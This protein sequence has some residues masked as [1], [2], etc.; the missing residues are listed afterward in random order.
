M[1]KTWLLT[2]GS[3]N[4]FQH[5][6]RGKYINAAITVGFSIA[7]ILYFSFTMDHIRNRA[8]S[9]RL[10]HSK[11][12]TSLPTI[13]APKNVVA[14]SQTTPTNHTW[15][16]KPVKG[17]IAHPETTWML[18]K[19]QDDPADLD[20]VEAPVEYRAKPVA[21]RLIVMTMNRHR[22]LKR[23]LRSAAEA[24]YGGHRIDLDIWVDRRSV[25]EEL[26]ANVLNVTETQ[27]WPHGTKTIYRRR[28]PGGLYQQWIW[29]WNPSEDSDEFA[30]ILEDDLELSP[31]WYEWLTEARR[32]YGND[33]DT[34]GFTLQRL[35]LQL[36]GKKKILT[37]PENTPVFK[38]H[39][40][41]SWGF[42]PKR[43]V[44]LEFRKWFEETVRAGKKPYVHDLLSS[45]WY[46][47]QDRRHLGYAPSMWTQWFIKFV[48][49]RSYFTV[50]PHLLDG[51][52][53][54]ANWKEPGLHYSRKNR[55]RKDFP[56]F[57]GNSTQ[58]S[59]P[60]TLLKFDWDGTILNPEA[61]DE[62]V[63]M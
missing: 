48:D 49:E 16:P 34:A 60:K 20:T 43:E 29:T 33:K 53:V 40:L 51:T 23:L 41:G 44:W 39:L 7:L 46:R 56:L 18:V 24:R 1:N 3:K 25:E 11:L 32:R 27:D 26:D 38:N 5:Q 31:A 35:I 17:K 14:Q 62:N 42:A 4:V 55:P 45:R 15:P 63:Q 52:T 6:P 37:F 28:R 21:A 36:R 8:R 10:R 13:T 54:C 59:W 58:F 47:G 50:T 22:A 30:L 19:P 12:F 57:L 61:I 2:R 9:S